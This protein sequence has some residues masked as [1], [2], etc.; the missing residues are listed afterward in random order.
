MAWCAIFVDTLN[1][2]ERAHGREHCGA[3]NSVVDA[4]RENPV[5]AVGGSSQSMET[6]RLASTRVFTRRSTTRPG[7]NPLADAREAIGYAGSVEPRN[8]HT[9]VNTM[10]DLCLAIS[11]LFMRYNQ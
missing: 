6:T 2:T 10:L 3:M 5:F 7:E 9:L 1:P 8:V 11:R 4:G